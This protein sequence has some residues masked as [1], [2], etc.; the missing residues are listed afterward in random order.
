MTSGIKDM[1]TRP[2]PNPVMPWVKPAQTS[3]RAKKGQC[4]S[5]LR[6]AGHQGGPML[7]QFALNVRDDFGMIG[8]HIHSLA[9]IHPEVEEQ[10]G[11]L[12]FKFHSTGDVTRRGL[13]VGFV[14][15]FAE[16]K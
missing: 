8:R 5:V 12:F 16:R 3:A 15:P 4:I 7:F 13:K 6:F 10:R 2:K 1:E 11:L 14:R 9:G